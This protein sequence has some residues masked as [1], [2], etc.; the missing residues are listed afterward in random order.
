MLSVV[1][2][3]HAELAGRHV[4]D[5]GAAEG[6]LSLAAARL[7]AVALELIELDGNALDGARTNLKLNGLAERADFRLLDADLADPAGVVKRLR[8]GESPAVLVCNIGYWDYSATNAEAILLLDSIPRAELFIGGGYSTAGIGGLAHMRDDAELLG[9]LGFRVRA[10]M[11]TTRRRTWRSWIGAETLYALMA[12][13]ASSARLSHEEIVRSLQERRRRAPARL[14]A[15][16]RSAQ[17]WLVA[18]GFLLLLGA[19]YYLFRAFQ[20]MRSG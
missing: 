4:I 10:E 7:G 18:A 13:K 17:R 12:G 15:L 8:P 3:L 2:L 16:F 14:H 19:A 20:L 11:A 6:I 5:A 1:A 9:A